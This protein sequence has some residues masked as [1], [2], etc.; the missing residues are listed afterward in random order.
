M[1][2]LLTRWFTF[3]G[4]E[5]E[6][7]VAPRRFTAAGEV[8]IDFKPTLIPELKS[9]HQH[10]VEQFG[11]LVAAHSRGHLDECIEK[12]KL[13]TY[14][15]R[16]HLLKE[17]LHLYVYLKHALQHDAEST[18]LVAELRKEMQRIGR[19]LND[20]VTR[21]TTT[22]WDTDTRRELGNELESIGEVLSRRIRH[23]E[24]VLYPLYMPHRSYR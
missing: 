3:G 9:D 4:A 7:E 11:A 24:S 19:A 14:T 21:Y 12:L 23:E 1:Y 17:N 18:E 10:L 5:K 22:P 15:L 8:A 20:F 13:F 16:A 2:K 6:I